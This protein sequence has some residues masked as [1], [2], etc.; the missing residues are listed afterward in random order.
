MRTPSQTVGP[1]YAIG[2]CRRDDSVLDP[3]GVPL[4]GTLF[5]GQGEPVIDGMIELWDPAGRRWGRSGTHPD[6][7]FS[8]VVPRVEH[9]ECIVFARG[10]L[11]HQL[12]RVYFGEPDLPELSDEERATV[13][14]VDEGGAFRFDIRMQGDRATVFF[15]H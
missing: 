5:D 8:F 14:A 7:H 11:R 12:T 15:A 1:Y 6:G 13:V 9:L 3:D 4:R 10:L 2:T